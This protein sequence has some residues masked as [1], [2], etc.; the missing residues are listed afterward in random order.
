[1]PSRPIWMP[2]NDL[3][4][5]QRSGSMDAYIMCSVDIV[6]IRRVVCIFVSWLAGDGCN[7]AE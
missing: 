6:N 1:M 4:S 5:R 7:A 2:I 3:V